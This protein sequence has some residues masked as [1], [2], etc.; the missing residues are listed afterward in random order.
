MPTKNES[1]N[2]Q[3][4]LVFICKQTINFTVHFFLEILKRYC[5]F[6]VLGT[7]SIPDH[8]HQKWQYLF[9]DKCFIFMQKIKFIFHVFL[10]IFQG[11]CKLVPLGTLDMPD[12]THQ[13]RNFDDYLHAHN[14][15]QP[16]LLS[17]DI[18]ML[19]QSCYFGYFGI[20]DHKNQKY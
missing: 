16:S 12:H 11:H 1:I 6:V 3:K 18:V 2:L 15:L 20:P 19:M 9:L 17:K 4:T 13:N 5:K 7:L 14:Q 10:K 8:N